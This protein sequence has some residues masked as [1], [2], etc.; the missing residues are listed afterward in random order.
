MTHSILADQLRAYM[1]FVA[2]YEYSLRDLGKWW[3]MVTLI[4]KINSQQVAATL[5]DDMEDTKTRFVE[6]QERLVSNL[7]EQNLHK[8]DQEV[9]ARSQVAIDILIRNLF[10]RTAD[11]GFL[12]TDD[13]IRSFLREP[14]PSPE[15]QQA[16][17]A[18]LDEYTQKYTVYDEILILDRQGRVRAHLDADNP[19]S[20]SADPLIHAT[21]SSAE[22]YLETF[23]HS[24]LQPLRRHAHI[25]SAPISDSDAPDAPVLG[26]LCLCFR[27]ED[28]MSGIF[29]NLARSGEIVAILDDKNQLI[30]S[31]DPERVHL[32][33]DMLHPNGMAL[34]ILQ[35]NNH[36][37]L[38]RTSQT[39]GYQGYRGLGWQGHV[40]HGAAG[41]FDEH[42]EQPAMSEALL[43]NSRCIPEE[44]RQIARHAA[45]VTDDLTLIVLNG[46]II[47]AKRDAKEFMPVLDE[48][49]TIGQRTKGV[50]D[51][52]IAKLHNTV[53]NSL[54]SE[55]QFQAFLAV[56][57]MDR[58]LYER[59]NDVR[60]WALTTRFRHILSHGKPSDEELG[61]LANTLAYIND[62]YTV[63]TNLFI[64]D[65]ERR[66]LAVSNGNERHLLD[67]I[68]PDSPMMHAALSVMDTQRYVVSPFSAS[69]LYGGRH[70]YLYLTSILS[71]DPQQK[72]V[73]GIGIVFDA[74][75]QFRAMLEDALPCD[76]QGRPVAGSF[77][78]FV[79]R[80]G[81]I[82]ASTHPDRH[83]GEQ[84]KLAERFH[85]LANGDRDSAIVELDKQYYAVGAAMSQ[86]YREYKTSGDYTNDVLALIFVP[87]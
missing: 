85:L 74:E 24:D 52:S 73:G 20:H 6:L 2:A 87:V 64:F 83:P 77:A 54:L 61:T 60:W 43:Q 82:I 47:S 53:L 42:S 10:E 78:L 40:M 55:V 39:R 63:Y 13:D 45:L 84:L 25:F 76:A 32:G 16:I 56:D 31:S 28:E 38:V 68:L 15:A 50:F 14:D 27:F 69:P 29:A 48:I 70:T 8:L 12:A 7:L 79:G 30:A 17:V 49:R 21:L 26:L 3:Q 34:H 71:L 22:P 62:L 9:S 35:H 51:D 86:G 59:A 75:P 33:A 58:N 80:D 81:H 44:I 46:Q 11:V 72:V 4:G 5:L 57:I 23:R 36:D 66:I 67:T 41:A 65:T 37:F 19:V 18:R 1:P